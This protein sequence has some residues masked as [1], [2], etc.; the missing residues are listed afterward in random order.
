M[1]EE[2]KWIESNSLMFGPFYFEI[3]KLLYRHR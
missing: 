2:G 3:P 1:K